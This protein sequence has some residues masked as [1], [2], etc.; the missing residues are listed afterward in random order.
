MIIVFVHYL[1][2]TVLV[3]P[4]TVDVCFEVLILFIFV[5]EGRGDVSLIGAEVAGSAV[6]LTCM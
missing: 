3:E 4:T 5:S 1:S 6:R 2:S